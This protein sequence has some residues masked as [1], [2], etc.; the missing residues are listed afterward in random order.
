MK[1]YLHVVKRKLERTSK[2]ANK[3]QVLL[4]EKLGKHAG[5]LASIHPKKRDKKPFKNVTMNTIQKIETHAN[6]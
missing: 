6:R 5:N 3:E 4:S 2:L 1:S